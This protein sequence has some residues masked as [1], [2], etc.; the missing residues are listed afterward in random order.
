M[1]GSFLELLGPGS[2]WKREHI[3][4]QITDPVLDTSRKNIERVVRTIWLAQVPLKGFDMFDPSV[5]VLRFM[6]PEQKQAKEQANRALWRRERRNRAAQAMLYTSTIDVDS[7]GTS[8]TKD[9][10][11]SKY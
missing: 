8:S 11:F 2:W 7:V 9:F 10:S 3:P 1:V 6:T 4:D 5:N